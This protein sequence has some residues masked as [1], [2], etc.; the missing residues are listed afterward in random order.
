[1]FTKFLRES[2]RGLPSCSASPAEVQLP[3]QNEIVISTESIENVFLKL[4]IKIG[5]G[6]FPTRK[7]IKE[8]VLAI[9]NVAESYKHLVFLKRWLLLS[10]PEAF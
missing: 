1:M 4:I 9:C 2:T 3:I 6:F 7:R 5:L 8:N 10:H